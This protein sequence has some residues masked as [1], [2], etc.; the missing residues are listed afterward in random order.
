MILISPGHTL[1]G[2]F[3]YDMVQYFAQNFETSAKIAIS[4]NKVCN[5]QFNN[6]F[7]VNVEKL[8]NESHENVH[9]LVNWVCLPS[10]NEAYTINIQMFMVLECEII[11][12][13]LSQ[14]YESNSSRH[15]F[16]QF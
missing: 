5:K 13:I 4:D 8:S 12:L 7:V 14:N 1:K 16:E 9:N 6:I 2:L 11:T 10:K 15:F 3:P